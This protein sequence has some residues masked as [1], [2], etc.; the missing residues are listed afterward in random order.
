[1][2]NFLGKTDIPLS[3]IDQI[4]Q[5]SDKKKK[6]F[7]Q[8]NKTTSKIDAL[9]IVCKN[10]RTLKFGFRETEIKKGYLIASALSKFAFPNQHNLLFAYKFPDKYY[11]SIRNMC[12]FNMKKDWTM[13][14]QRCRTTGW[15]VMMAEKEM[16]QGALPTFIVIPR[17]LTDAEYNEFSRYF[18]NSL[19]AIWVWGLENA[20]LVRMA[21]LI[22][23]NDTVRFKEN[24]MMEIIRNCHPEKRTP[25][26]QELTKILPSIQDVQAAYQK[27]RELCV[28]DNARQ[29]MMQENRFLSQLE[30][31]CWLLYVSLCLKYSDEMAAKMRQGETVVLQENDGRDMSAVISSL[32]QIIL[33]QQARTISGFQS[34]VQKEWVALGH[35]FSDRHGLVINA[36]TS[37]QSPVFLLFLD[38]VWQLLK[39]FPEDFEYSETY[40]TTV[41]DSVF[42]SIFDTF[43]FNCEY[44]RYQ[45]ADREH[46]ILR[47]VWDWGEQ[48]NDK[49]IA[50][51]SNPLYKRPESAVNAR[52]SVMLPPNAVPL[53]ILGANSFNSKV[54]VVVGG[55]GNTPPV[56]SSQFLEEINTNISDLEIWQQCYYRWLPYLELQNGGQP[57]ID[58]FHRILLNNISKLQ[59]SL[60]TGDFEELASSNLRS[61]DTSLPAINSFFPFSRNT[62]LNSNEL[63]EIFTQS[64]DIL[65]EGSIFDGLSLAQAP[66]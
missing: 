14:M 41:W 2:N 60:Q 65:T 46:L 26:L 42:M 28:P 55:G 15:R 24:S 13:E 21:D 4:Y 19:P 30:K 34:L 52:K 18:R 45:A 66:D 29:F 61:T 57:Q 36:N 39:Q 35:P 56:T 17:S 50:L 9:Q 33:D 48:F 8:R 53:P 37:E 31:S 20:A 11:N 51:F 58:L 10:F 7:N 16:P 32:M 63:I 6:P 25:H 22:S 64:S 38:C 5:F 3:L 43:Q 23:A 12:F 54:S 40:L 62:C 27:L 47:P 1:M 59:Q 49:D 44:D